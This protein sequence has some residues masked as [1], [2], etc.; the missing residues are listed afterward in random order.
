MAVPNSPPKEVPASNAQRTMPKST[1]RN[2]L[3]VVQIISE[4]TGLDQEQLSEETTFESIGVDSLLSLIITSRLKDEL[5]FDIGSRSSIFDHFSTVGELENELARLEGL[6]PA[7]N[8]DASSQRS[9]AAKAIPGPAPLFQALA[10]DNKDETVAAPSAAHPLQS[11]ENTPK[12]E[13]TNSILPCTSLVL[14]HSCHPSSRTIFLFPDGSGSPYS[15]A[16]ISQIHPG[17]TVI[18]LACPYRREP[19]AM[20]VSSLDAIM[21]S[22]ICQIRREQ[23]YGPYS[24][25]G[26]SSGG[27]LAFEAARRLMASTE[28]VRHLVLIDS[29]APTGGLQKLPSRFYKHAVT[30][31]AF[32]QIGAPT[33]SAGATSADTPV[34]EGSPPEWLIPHFKATVE[35]LHNYRPEPL[36]MPQGSAV[37]WTP[38]GDPKTSI[39]WARKRVFDGVK[40]PAMPEPDGT[41]SDDDDDEGIKFLTEERTDFSPGAWSELLP[42]RDIMV[43]SVDADHFS[44]M[45]RHPIPS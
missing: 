10:H 25:G 16:H 22:Y 20:L 21:D 30:A 37:D 24:L 18:G 5:A 6:D 34:V 27:I 11:L 3:R 1:T 44:I 8:L 38:G 42:G 41:D 4:E 29:P 12:P 39:I 36:P 9:T 19:S 28:T 26:W 14:Q 40:F 15:Y 35:L 7:S 43:E 23:P 13:N 31:G 17:L 2:L 45:V 33:T 32:A